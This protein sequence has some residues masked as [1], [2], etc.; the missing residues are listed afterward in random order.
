MQT[1]KALDFTQFA[2]TMII[3]HENIAPYILKRIG[4]DEF[5]FSKFTFDGDDKGEYIFQPY[6][7]FVSS[8]THLRAN[9]PASNPTYNAG[10][11]ITIGI[12]RK[13]GSTGVTDF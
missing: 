7:K 4:Q 11:S 5:T 3:V 2:D 12:Y 13:N 8:D 1:S 9:N 6:H 10:D